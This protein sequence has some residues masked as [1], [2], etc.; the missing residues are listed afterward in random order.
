MT[1]SR[2]AELRTVWVMG[3]SVRSGRP[4]RMLSAGVGSGRR[5]RP[6]AARVDQCVQDRSGVRRLEAGRLGAASASRSPPHG[7]SVATPLLDVFVVRLLAGLHRRL[8]DGDWKRLVS[9]PWRSPPSRSVDLHRDVAPPDRDE[10]GHQAAA[11]TRRR[12][13]ARASTTARRTAGDRAASAVQRGGLDG[14]SAVR[15]LAEPHGRLES[16]PEPR[17]AAAARQPRELRVVGLGEL[18]DAAVVAE[19]ERRAARG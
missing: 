13:I 9:T 12:W 17:S 10:R 8:V 11:S 5:R 3:P 2:V 16:Q 14:D 6:H 19:V 4:R 1:T 15:E 18:D 7:R